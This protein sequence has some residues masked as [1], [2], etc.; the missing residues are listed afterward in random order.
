MIH[1]LL[2][3]A[4]WVVVLGIAYLAFGP[5]LFDSSRNA[6]PFQSDTKLFL[7]PP[8]LQRQIEYEEILKGRN[9]EGEE[10]AEYRALV[11]ERQSKFWASEGI[12]VEEVLSGVRKQRKAYLVARL[13]ERGMS[14]EELAVF[15]TVVERD[16][17]ALLSDR[18]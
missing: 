1:V 15:L 10:L 17:A 4:V 13:L 8:K 5:Q 3:V 11:Q 14:N 18:E 2:R 7:P 16:Q 9:L 6:S 12:S